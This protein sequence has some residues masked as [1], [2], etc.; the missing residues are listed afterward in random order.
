MYTH[1]LVVRQPI[2]PCTDQ[3]P[4]MPLWR[5]VQGSSVHQHIP[6]ERIPVTSLVQGSGSTFPVSLSST[7]Q[8]SSAFPRHLTKQRDPLPRNPTAQPP[9]EGCQEVLSSATLV[10]Q[11]LRSSSGAREQQENCSFQTQPLLPARRSPCQEK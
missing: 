2:H 1:S 5:P 4:T 10:L 8:T 7:A 6:K 9:V 3:D 11:P